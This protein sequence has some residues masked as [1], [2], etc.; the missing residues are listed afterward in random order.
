[1]PRSDTAAPVTAICGEPALNEQC[2]AAK[3]EDQVTL[4]DRQA[5][6]LSE[7]FGLHAVKG[8]IGHAL[9]LFAGI[10]R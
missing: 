1:M 6:R 9:S 5:Q 7:R 10:R 2:L 3:L 4:A 8:L